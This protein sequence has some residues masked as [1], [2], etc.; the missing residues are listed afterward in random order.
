[1]S[2]PADFSTDRLRLS[3]LK[4]EDADEI[5]YTYASKAEATRFVTW[6]TH[7]RIRDTRDFLRRAVRARKGGLDYSYS[8]RLPDNRLIGSIGA[9]HDRGSVQ[10]GYVLGPLHWGKGYATEACQGL[11]AILLA[12][13]RVTM[14]HS[15]V[16]QD[17]A[18]SHRV[19]TKCGFEAGET[20]PFSFI[21]QQNRV[22]ECRIYRFPLA[23]RA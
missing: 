7:T 21:N 12:D 11:L 1:M 16:D 22:K 13:S 15:F 19:L 9:V 6:P 4:Y 18:A 23:I 2:L 10:L 5:F 3:W 14:L 20:T 8:L 17:N